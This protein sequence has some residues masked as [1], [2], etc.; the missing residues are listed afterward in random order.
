MSVDTFQ[1]KACPQDVGNRST[2]AHV[3]TV[4]QSEL[5]HLRRAA[6]SWYCGGCERWGCVT[7]GWKFFLTTFLLRK[8][9]HFIRCSLFF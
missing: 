5:S 4:Y 3:S 2:L 8:D 1:L 9:F 7:G 6:A